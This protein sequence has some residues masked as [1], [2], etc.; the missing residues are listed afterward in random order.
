M[1]PLL[2]ADEAARLRVGVN[3][4]VR[5][6]EPA[7]PVTTA[8]A[9]FDMTPIA[10][11]DWVALTGPCPTCEGCTI[12]PY[13]LCDS[14][15]HDMDGDTRKCPV[16]GGGKQPLLHPYDVPKAGGTC[17]S[18]M[19]GGCDFDPSHAGSCSQNTEVGPCP[20]CRDGRKLTDFGNGV[21]AIV[22]SVEP[23]QDGRNWRITLEVPE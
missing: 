7:R 1:T 10:P 11:Q 19:S 5:P 22:V 20:D 2:T 21:K 8:T 17:G 14:A 23:E 12:V 18:L 3:V 4:I 16:C 15:R 6:G 13:V 9:P